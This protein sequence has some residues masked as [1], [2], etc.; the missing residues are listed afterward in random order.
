[1]L[2]GVIA[3]LIGV[4]IFA[5]IKSIPVIGLMGHEYQSIV[6]EDEPHTVLYVTF[7]DDFNVSDKGRFAGIVKGRYDNYIA[8]YVKGD[9]QQEYL[10]ADS[11]FY[12]KTNSNPFDENWL[13]SDLQTEKKCPM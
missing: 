13:N 2:R 11:R 5:V 3:L 1:M 6:S 9:E 8:Y 7:D 10:Y 12:K 4:M